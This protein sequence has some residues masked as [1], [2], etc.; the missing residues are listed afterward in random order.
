MGT[1]ILESHRIQDG[2]PWLRHK[3]RELQGCPEPGR[4]EIHWLVQSPDGSLDATVFNCTK[5][6]EAGQVGFLMAGGCLG[7]VQPHI[8]LHLGYILTSLPFRL[9]LLPIWGKQD[10]TSLSTL[11]SFSSC[12]PLTVIHLIIMNTVKIIGSIWFRACRFTSGEELVKTKRKTIS[13]EI[14]HPYNMASFDVC[15]LGTVS[16]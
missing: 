9:L 7:C 5:V 13:V 12:P 2:G 1:A 10:E 8:P 11:L 4:F 14:S 15:F 6:S 3:K 16:C